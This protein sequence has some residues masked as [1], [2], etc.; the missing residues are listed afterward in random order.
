MRIADVCGFYSD[1]GGGVR[2]YVRQKLRAAERLGHDLT[3]IA[4]GPGDRLE[5]HG[6]NG[7]IVWLA[8]PLMPF[9]PNYHVFRDR[10]AVW[11]ALDAARPDI[12][13]ASSPWGS[14][15]MAT[16]WPGRAIR[17]LV[18]HQDFVAG[19]PY[20]ALDRALSHGA[21]DSLFATYWR[22]IRRLS[23]AC[24]VTVTGG[25]WLAQRLERHGVERAVAAP[26]GLEPGAFSPARRDE[27]LRARLLAECGVGPNGRLLL[28]VGRLHPEKRHGVMIRGFE[29]ARASRPDIGLVIIGEGP[30]RGAIERRLR[31]TP[32]MRLMAPTTD[33]DR[34]ATLYASADLLVHGS[35]AETY[36]LVVAEAMASGLRVL[37]PDLGGAAELARAGGGQTY[38]LGDGFDCGRAILAALASPGPAPRPPSWTADHHFDA[39][40]GLYAKLL[41]RRAGRAAATGRRRVAG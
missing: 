22:H 16:A 19:Y 8:N 35:G 37:T 36:G 12:V 5:A 41:E 14:A 2:S 3:V 32:G 4:P 26:F 24:E 38:A 23:R 13:E 17:S 39:L 18:F 30:S 1:R 11:R 40:F 28:A 29:V 25:A 20:T 21:I 27:A 7:R 33:R 10:A 9:D 15:V 31:S 6:R 34:L